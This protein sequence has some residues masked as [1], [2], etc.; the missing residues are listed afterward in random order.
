MFSNC[1][2][3][4]DVNVDVLTS[5]QKHNAAATAADNSRIKKKKGRPQGKIDQYSRLRAE[6]MDLTGCKLD[7]LKVFILHSN[8]QSNTN[9]ANNKQ[10]HYSTWQINDE[11]KTINAANLLLNNIY[12]CSRSDSVMH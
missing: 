9:D 10:Q 1:A 12:A 6:H 3:V 2:F 5:W 4:Y 11:V 7:L 8:N